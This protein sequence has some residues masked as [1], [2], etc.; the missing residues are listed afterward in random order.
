MSTPTTKQRKTLPDAQMGLPAKG[1]YPLDTLARA[2][3]AKARARQELNAGNLE[4]P[5]Y[6]QI[7]SKAAA[8]VTA[9]GGNNGKPAMKGGTK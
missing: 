6:K 2:Q 4:W 9:L 8:R 3:N 5:E 1:K 7:V